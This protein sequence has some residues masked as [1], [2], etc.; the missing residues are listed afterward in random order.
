MHARQCLQSA[1]QTNT[2]APKVF[3]RKGA[4]QNAINSL[5]TMNLDGENSLLFQNIPIRKLG[6]IARM[7][8]TSSLFV[9]PNDLLG[10]STIS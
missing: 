9:V 1:Q 6:E 10:Y 5:E 8:K 7:V 4:H 2:M 3:F